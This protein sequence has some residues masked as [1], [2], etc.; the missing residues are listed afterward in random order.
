M[1]IV[2]VLL[3]SEGCTSAQLRTTTLN[4]GSTLVDIQ[5][6][7]ILRNLATTAHPAF[8]GAVQNVADPATIKHM[9]GA[10][11]PT[12]TYTT[13]AQFQTQGCKAG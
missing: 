13:A 3:A 10:Y 11:L 2:L 1:L 4:Q 8:K 7:M 5:Y 9:M 6:Q 12:V